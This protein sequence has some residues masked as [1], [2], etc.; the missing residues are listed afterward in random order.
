MNPNDTTLSAFLVDRF[1][2]RAL[3][4]KTQEVKEGTVGAMSDKTFEDCVRIHLTNHVSF[5]GVSQ[6][7]TEYC[8]SVGWQ[9]SNANLSITGLIAD[10]WPM[11]GYFINVICFYEEPLN[12]NVLCIN[13]LSSIT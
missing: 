8:D 1:G 4:I 5:E 10:I 9:Y 6:A 11:E 13:L 3:P 12:A 2:G 7:L